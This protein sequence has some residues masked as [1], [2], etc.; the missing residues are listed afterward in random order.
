MLTV[1][2]RHAIDPATPRPRHGRAAL[3][4]PSPAGMFA[5]GEIRLVYTHY[6]RLVLGGAVPGGRA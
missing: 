1:E 6:D 4:F 5:D 2:T 3:A